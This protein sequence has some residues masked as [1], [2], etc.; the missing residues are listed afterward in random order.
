MWVDWPRGAQ[1]LEAGQLID[2]HGSTA[3]RTL[4]RISRG[5]FGEW[6]GGHTCPRP[7]GHR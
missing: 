6:W 1:K 3:H 7:S 5:R 4:H 2:L